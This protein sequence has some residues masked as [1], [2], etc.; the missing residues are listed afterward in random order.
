MGRGSKGR[1]AILACLPLLCL[2][3]ALFAAPGA[4]QP[5]VAHAASGPTV[6]SSGTI[7]KGGPNCNP[8]YYGPF[9]FTCAFSIPVQQGDLIVVAFQIAYYDGV[10]YNTLGLTD[11][12]GTSFVLTAH[13]GYPNCYTIGE[14]F[15]TGIYYGIAQ[16]SSSSDTITMSQSGTSGYSAPQ[17]AAS[18]TME[19]YDVSFAGQSGTPGLASSAIFNCQYQDYYNPN[20]CSGSSTPMTQPS[21]SSQSYGSGS[22]LIGALLTT[23]N[24]VSGGS[25]FTFVSTK[26]V[27]YNYCYGA[28]TAND[29]T[30]SSPTTFPFQASTVGGV[31]WGWAESAAV[32]TTFSGF[33][34]TPPP[35]STTTTHTIEPVQFQG[36][37]SGYD[38]WVPIVTAL[39]G[40]AVGFGIAFGWSRTRKAPAAKQ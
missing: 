25:G 3:L 6:F 28:E 15:E 5:P 36:A 37:S 38:L 26:C 21:V 17:S 30:V 11:S 29:N 39:V 4:F 23:G 20:N 34:S 7:V 12:V 31:Y 14:G 27:N 18:L 19:G 13:C 22:F 2:L 35:T 24:G 32:F 33:R 8:D 40:L 1:T 10:T 9:S 16:S